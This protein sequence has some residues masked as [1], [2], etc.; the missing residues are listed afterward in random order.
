VLTGAAAS[1]EL[2]PGKALLFNNFSI[3][4][5]YSS[6]IPVTSCHKSL[7]ILPEMVENIAAAD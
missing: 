5:K 4:C 7:D 1:G 6:Q 2:M 3:F